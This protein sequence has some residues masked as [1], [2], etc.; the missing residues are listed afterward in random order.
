MTTLALVKQR[1]KARDSVTTRL[2]YR[3]AKAVLTF[4]MPPIAAIYCP[5]SALVDGTLGGV[6]Y[7]RRTFYSK[8]VFLTRVSNHPKRL[9]FSGRGRPLVGG[10]LTI[11]MGDDC[12]ISTEIALF[13]RAS[14]VLRPTL[15]FGN[16][17]G[18]GW[19]CGFYSGTDITLEDNVRLAEGCTLVGYP[20]H[21]FDAAARAPDEDHQ[22][23][24]IKLER[25]VWL[26]RSVIV[27]AGVTIGAGTIVA[28]GSVVTRDL[29][30][31][32]LAGGVP[33]RVIR[34][35]KED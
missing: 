31:G 26:G 10:P 3:T 8:P 22:A 20:G 33:A 18:V 2:L 21:P 1:I 15:T 7:L 17:V 35:L 24:P 23:R 5:L 6:D 11:K 14:G 19:R 29:P 12:R 34:P 9:V 30:P 28:A 16:N 4:D 32:V 25:D 13:G 27:N